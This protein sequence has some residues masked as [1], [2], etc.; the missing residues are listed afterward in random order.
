MEP[1][2]ES[3]DELGTAAKRAPAPHPRTLRP[4]IPHVLHGYAVRPCARWIDRPFERAWHPGRLSLLTAASIG[5]G[6]AVRGTRS[7]LS[8]HR[9]NQWASDPIAFL[10]SAHRR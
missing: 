2:F 9:A 3:L 7:R 5:Y 8:S 1:L 4:V 10:Q 6:P